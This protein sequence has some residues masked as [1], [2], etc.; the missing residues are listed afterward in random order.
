MPT[1]HVATYQGRLVLTPEQEAFL[2]DYG[3]RYNHIERK[4]YAEMRSA[5]ISA[6]KFKNEYLGRFGITARQFNPYFA[7]FL[8]RKEDLSCPRWILSAGSH[9]YHLS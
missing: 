2:S 4:L 3:T 9:D 7:L 5:G 1:S 6:A 8:S